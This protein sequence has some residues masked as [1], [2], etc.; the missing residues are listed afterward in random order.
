MGE[1]NF[2]EDMARFSALVL[3]L[4]VVQ[5]NSESTEE[6]P[7]RVDPDVQRAGDAYQQLEVPQSTFVEMLPPQ[8]ADEEL[9]SYLQEM[10][11]EV[12]DSNK[13]LRAAKEALLLRFLCG[14]P[15]RCGAPRRR[16]LRRPLVV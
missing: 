14:G 11:S 8:A 15:C 9:P 1:R 4:L 6:S 5:V 10:K 7:V 12:Q 3:L 16:G 13:K 2:E